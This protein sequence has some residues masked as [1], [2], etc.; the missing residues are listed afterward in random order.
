MSWKICGENIYLTR[1]DTFPCVITPMDE[2]G[3]VHEFSDG[4]VYR[5]AVKKAYT[6]IECVLEKETD[7]S[8]AQLKLTP[9][10]TADLE[11]GKY[12]YDVEITTASGDK[13]TVI[14]AD[15]TAEARLILCKEVD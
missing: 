5:F 13:Y 3:N 6:D 11:F 2:D 14:P 7:T 15:P 12:V 4:D 9:E 10:D 1:G 8:T